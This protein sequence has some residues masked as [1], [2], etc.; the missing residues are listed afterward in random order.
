M[1]LL[2]LDHGGDLDAAMLQYGGKEEDWLD[3]STGINPEHYRLTQPFTKISRF[4][5][6][7][8]YFIPSSIPPPI[9]PIILGLI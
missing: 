8:T 4:H 7:A 1:T 9:I 2:P 5:L 3:L 6:N